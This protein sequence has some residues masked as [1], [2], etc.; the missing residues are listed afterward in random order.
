L[1]SKDYS[2]WV[3]AMKVSEEYLRYVPEKP[4]EIKGL[5]KFGGWRK[6][7]REAVA[8]TLEFID[9]GKDVIVLVAPTGFGKSLYAMALDRVLFP[10]LEERGYDGKDKAYVV[11]ETKQLQDQYLRDFPF[12]KTIKGRSNYPCPYLGLTANECVERAGMTCP[13]REQCPYLR[14]R[15]EAIASPVTIHN[16]AYFLNALNYT[17]IWPYA[18]LTVFDEGHLAENKLVEFVSFSISERQVKS[19][20]LSLPRKIT[21]DTL[22]PFLEQLK[23]NVNLAILDVKEAL[24]EEENPKRI[25]ELTKELDRLENL[26]RKIVFLMAKYEPGNWII[27]RAERVLEVRPIWVKDYGDKLTGHA[28]INVFMSATISKKTVELLGIPEER[29]GYIEVPAIFPKEVRPI[30]IPRGIPRISKKTLKEVLPKLLLLIDS[31]LKYHFG[32][33]H[34]GVIHTANTGLAEFILRN[35]TFRDR[36]IP[37]WGK[38]RANNLQRYLQSREPVALVSP[39][40]EV[41]TDLK[42]DDGRFQIIARVP[43]PNLG[44]EIVRK[45]FEQDRDWFDMVTVF[46]LVQAYGRTNRAEDDFSITYILDANVYRLLRNPYMPEWVRE[47][48]TDGRTAL[49]R[50]ARHLNPNDNNS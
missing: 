29:I 12:I 25:Q 35:S 43:F 19:V 42:Y 2:G 44:D 45:R 26:F 49:S 17:R 28:D 31:I 10:F 5:E 48:V 7:Q 4:S 14:A 27:K 34:K 41:G 6:H 37:A 16:Y 21:Q 46:R 40:L 15:A 50:M 32:L 13:I 22:L 3:V 8:K 20:G 38:D 33:G 30:V 9:S 47:A 23:Y 39:S 18:M 1:R 24:G 36:L 11:T